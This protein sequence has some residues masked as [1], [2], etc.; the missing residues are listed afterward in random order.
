MLIMPIFGR[1]PADEIVIAPNYYDANSCLIQAGQILARISKLDDRLVGDISLAA[2][3]LE[4]GD[5][6]VG[7]QI[8]NNVAASINRVT[9]PSTHSI[10]IGEYAYCMILT[11]QFLQAEKMIDSAFVLCQ[12]AKTE[13]DFSWALKNISESMI[14][15]IELPGGE[16]IAEKAYLISRFV[17]NDYHQATLLGSIAVV[18]VMLGQTRECNETLGSAA[19]IANGIYDLGQKSQAQ[20][21][22]AV[23]AVRVWE[24]LADNQYLNAANSIA[25]SIKEDSARIGARCEI[26]EV[27][28]KSGNTEDAIKILY[29]AIDESRRIQIPMYRIAALCNVAA[30]LAKLGE[31]AQVEKLVLEA[32]S[33]L[34]FIADKLP[35]ARATRKIVETLYA[36]S[37]S[38]FDPRYF[39]QS[40]HCT[41]DLIDND[42]YFYG[43]ILGVKTL[44]T[45]TTI[46]LKLSKK[47]T[48]LRSE[49][50]SLEK[51]EFSP[52]K[53]GECIDKANESYNGWKILDA[54]RWV[55]MAIVQLLLHKKKIK[56]YTIVASKIQEL[57]H[58]AIETKNSP[59]YGAITECI[60]GLKQSLSDG[61]FEE[62]DAKI[63]KCKAMISSVQSSIKP[64]LR[65]VIAL[66]KKIKRNTWTPLKIELFNEGNQK[67]KDIEVQV[68]PPFRVLG[69][70]KANMLNPGETGTITVSMKSED[71]GKLPLLL[72]LKYVNESGYTFTVDIN[73]D[74][75]IEISE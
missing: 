3:Y 8:L 41:H 53:V 36:I 60:T 30:S 28:S 58:V 38:S 32:M 55:S 5:G 19:R 34:N 2:T 74:L 51:S 45:A 47:I 61:Q 35:K 9:N 56:E 22:V 29:N 4:R 27:F 39:S 54:Q 20:R 71:P 52:T 68:D 33:G 63:A 73:Q 48:K 75:W 70:L 21:Q 17:K 13:S 44:C 62:I 7:Q 72:K 57:E 18:Q 15:I 25:S 66:D 46:P 16:K 24:Y 42:D 12:E 14:K 43:L 59:D 69:N 64:N 67:V 40:L 50:Q 6:Q 1:N 37:L 65:C 26:A 49:F 10:I 31:L 11:G 23:S